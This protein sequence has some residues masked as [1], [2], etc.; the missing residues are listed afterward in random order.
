MNRRRALWAIAGITCAI[1]ACA[2]LFWP[3]SP[4]VWYT[5]EPVGEP[6]VEVEILIPRGWEKQMQMGIDPGYIKGYT[7][8]EP[9]RPR[10]WP[11]FLRRWFP[12]NQNPSNSIMFLAGPTKMIDM[13][14]SRDRIVKSTSGQRHVAIRRIVLPD[15]NTVK[16]LLARD[17]THTNFEPE[18]AIILN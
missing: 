13:L 5:S 14:P 7:I 17:I 4:Y 18:K 3:R 2:Y 6:G 15:G 11:T 16:I 9:D 10:W 12:A 8:G 1:A